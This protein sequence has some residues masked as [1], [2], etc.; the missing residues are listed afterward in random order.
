MSFPVRQAKLV[1]SCKVKVLVWRNYSISFIRFNQPPVS[2]VASS[3]E[4]LLA[5]KTAA[6]ANKEDEAYTENCIG[7]RGYA[8]P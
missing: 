1:I 4:R 6:K 2:S 3:A 5:V 8:H 7:H